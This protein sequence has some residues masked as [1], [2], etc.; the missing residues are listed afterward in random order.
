MCCFLN[1]AD[2]GELMFPKYCYYS[3]TNELLLKINYLEGNE[4]ERFRLISEQKR[5]L[6]NIISNVDSQFQ[7][8]IKRKSKNKPKKRNLKEKIFNKFSYLFYFFL[9]ILKINLID[10]LNLLPPLK[11]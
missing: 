9:L 2:Y 1:Y 6:D 4:E 3:D 5:I 10:K 11:E 8:A 7:Q